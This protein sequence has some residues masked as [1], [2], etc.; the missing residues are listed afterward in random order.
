MTHQ[1]IIKDET[2]FDKYIDS[3]FG[4]IFIFGKSFSASDILKMI[5]STTYDVL[6]SRNKGT[7]KEL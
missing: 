7:I 5:D 1:N 4:G 2:D 3:E 6:Y